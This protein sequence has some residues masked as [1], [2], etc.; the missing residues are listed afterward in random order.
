MIRRQICQLDHDR[1]QLQT[2]ITDKKYL[3]IY[4]GFYC[5]PH[6]FLKKM[7]TRLFFTIF[8]FAVFEQCFCAKIL[9]IVVMPSKSHEILVE[10]LLKEL[11][12]RG[13]EITLISPFPENKSVANISRVTVDEISQLYKGK[14]YH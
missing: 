13:H 14:P 9:G 12:K 6:L 10:R 4:F 7:K 11:G 5:L 8:S 2:S 1:Q 3:S